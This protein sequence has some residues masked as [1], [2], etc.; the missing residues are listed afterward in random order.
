M[1][2]E[3]AAGRAS[4]CRRR[5]LRRHGAVQAARRGCCADTGGTLQRRRRTLRRWPRCGLTCRRA[6]HAGRRGCARPSSADAAYLSGPRRPLRATS[7]QPCR[8]SLIRW[9]RRQVAGLP[10]ARRWPP[11]AP[12][13]SARCLLP[14]SWT[15]PS[16]PSP[17]PCAPCARP[18]RLPARLMAFPLFNV[19]SA[20]ARILPSPWPLL[21]APGRP[22]LWPVR[23]RCAGLSH[24]AGAGGPALLGRVRGRSPPPG[25]AW[26]GP[27]PAAGA[28]ASAVH[29]RAAAARGRGPGRGRRPVHHAGRVL[30]RVRG[31]ALLQ[32]AVWA[33]LAASLNTLPRRLEARSGSGHSPSPRCSRCTASCPSPSGTTRRACGR[34]SGVWPCPPP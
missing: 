5:L 6:R 1:S 2:P 12:W 16:S 23:A 11:P 21:V 26:D 8:P 25:P 20:W 17:P 27:L 30:V 7:T 10:A 3:Q 15:L 34:S 28:R 29:A 18:A 14:Q 9:A 4:S 13:S 31:A 22:A 33:G 19:S 32:A 24:A